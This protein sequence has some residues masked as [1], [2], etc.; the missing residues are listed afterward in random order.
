MMKQKPEAKR[1]KN[2]SKNAK[3]EGRKAIKQKIAMEKQQK[4]KRKE[5]ESILEVE[6]RREDI[7]DEVFGNNYGARSCLRHV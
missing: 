1:T 5:K 3:A 7:T 6:L 2:R 4:Q